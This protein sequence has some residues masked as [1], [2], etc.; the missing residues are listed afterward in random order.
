LPNIIKIAAVA[1]QIA[2]GPGLI[3]SGT[4]QAGAPVAAVM[5][6]EDGTGA[7]TNFPSGSTVPA[8]PTMTAE[9]WSFQPGVP[10]AGVFPI[11]VHDNT[12][13]SATIN[14]TVNAAPRGTTINEVLVG[15]SA[16]LTL[17]NGT[18]LSIRASDGAVLAG[19]TVIPNS[20]G[21]SAM[22]ASTVPD[23]VVWGQDAGSKLW[24][25]TPDTTS[26]AWTEASP[27][28]AISGWPP[29]PPPSGPFTIS[30]GQVLNNGSPFSA[31]GV[32]LLDGMMSS[33]SAATII[34]TFPGIKA[35]NLACGADG[36]GYATAQTNSAI[37]P[38]VNDATSKGLIVILSDYVPEQPTVRTGTDLQNS[39]N[40]YASLARAF[41]N[42]PNVWWT[43]ENEVFDTKPPGGVSAMHA[44]IYN[45]VRGTGNNGIIFMEPGN[46]QRIDVSIGNLSPSTYSNMRNIGWNAHI[47]PWDFPMT[48]N[49]ADYD[50]TT[51]SQINLYQKFAQSLDGVMP[52]IMGEG[53][54]STNGNAGPIDDRVING[55]FATMQSVI[56][57]TGPSMGQF[58]GSTF[59]LWSWYG[60]VG[61]GPDGVASD[62][63]VDNSGNLTDFGKQVA[64]GIAAP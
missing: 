21:S 5:P 14:V 1:A 46:E 36:N 44:A 31:K 26:G 2:G 24:Y 41:A 54:N 6:Y 28:P 56:N 16:T 47:Y 35:V 42:N 52:V 13:A 59:W 43:T 12:G 30:G 60:Q 58:C 62:T 39:L 33:V 29:P 9:P 61:T 49:Q 38:W 50:N 51:K 37:I 18:V 3:V 7:L 55:K 20:F 53:G 23:N 45:A 22:G 57:N 34:S 4:W 64:A 17:K 40:W 8:A 25:T 11:L 27:Q 48:H 10:T 15:S 32:T 19:S 63:L